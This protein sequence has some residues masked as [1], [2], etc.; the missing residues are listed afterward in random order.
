MWGK[1]KAG[2]VGIEPPLLDPLARATGQCCSLQDPSR[3]RLLSGLLFFL[4]RPA[5]LFSHTEGWSNTESPYFAFIT[6]STVSFRTTRCVSGLGLAGLGL[7]LRHPPQVSG[8][9]PMGVTR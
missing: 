1:P 9:Y 4:L 5:L 3:A 7:R 6:L 8:W 2:E